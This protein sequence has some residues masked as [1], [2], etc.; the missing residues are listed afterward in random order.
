MRKGGPYAGVVHG[1]EKNSVFAKME[2]TSNVIEEKWKNKH[3]F[4]T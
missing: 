3:L 2:E 4:G 1:F